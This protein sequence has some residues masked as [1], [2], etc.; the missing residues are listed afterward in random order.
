MTGSP[1]AE[2]GLQEEGTQNFEIG[3]KAQLDREDH[4]QSNR[5]VKQHVCLPKLQVAG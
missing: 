3:I 4:A 2:G 5:S 1:E